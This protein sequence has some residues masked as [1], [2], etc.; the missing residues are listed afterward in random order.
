MQSKNIKPL[1]SILTIAKSN[2]SDLKHTYNS[3]KSNLDKDKYLIE[4][5]LVLSGNF[6]NIEKKFLKKHNNVRVYYQPPKG[7]YHAMNSAIKYS[8]GNFSWFINSG[9]I[10]DNNYWQLLIDNLKI[11]YFDLHFFSVNVINKN[12]TF[13]KECS[14]KNTSKLLRIL[15]MLKMPPHHQGIIYRT[16]ILK[17]Y[18]FDNSFKI[19]G[20]Y[21]NLIRILQDN[22]KISIQ[23][24]LIPIATF[25]EGGVSNK[26]FIHYES[27]RAL[28]KNKS[29][30]LVS[31]FLFFY[32]FFKFHI[33]KLIKKII[34]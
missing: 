10:I 7:I 11:S 5:V 33:L 16:T 2:I 29:I 25:Y 26:K 4:W 28:S 9:D 3:L 22:K 14:I 34:I 18:L 24:Y 15:T 32:F 17:K 21:E 8:K 12:N 1:I 13:I 6:K 30:K 19:R 27:F 23:S 31:I 20:D